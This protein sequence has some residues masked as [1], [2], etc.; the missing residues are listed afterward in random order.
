MPSRKP[1]LKVHVTADFMV[2][3]DKAVKHSG[4]TKA[5]F[6]REAIAEAMYKEAKEDIPP[7]DD[8]PP[9]G[10]NRQPTG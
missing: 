4:K 3:L 2:A 9:H 5:N 10:G 1:Q 6:I 8:M 7:L